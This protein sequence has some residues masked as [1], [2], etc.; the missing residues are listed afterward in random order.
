MDGVALEHAA[1]LLAVDASRVRQL[2]EAG[3]LRAQR[4]GRSWLVSQEDVALRRLDRPLPGRPLAA[5]RAWAVLDLLDG[6]SAAWLSAPA[7]SQVRQSLRRLAA[8]DAARWRHALRARQQVLHL[9]AHSAAVVRLESEPA[10]LVAGPAA[11]AASG[12]D[13]VIPS[14]G[15]ASE[16]YVP[17]DVWPELSRRYRLDADADAG[18]ERASAN[19]IVRLPQGVWPF[20]VD[21]GRLDPASVPRWP[22]PAVLAADLLSHPEPRARGAGADLL[23]EL[24]SLYAKQPR[25]RASPAAPAS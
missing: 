17:P 4:I 18:Q 24:E 13:L 14:L 15:G 7:R 9:H 22:G 11:A 12:A 20:G 25:R 21:T 23:N 10:V 1:R 6:G 5:A 16:L 8:A 19:L 2:I 3:E